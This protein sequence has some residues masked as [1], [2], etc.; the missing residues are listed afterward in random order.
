MSISQP[1]LND[2][3]RSSSACQSAT[4]LDEWSGSCATCS[5]SPRSDR[6][7]WQ[8]PAPCE[9]CVSPLRVLNALKHTA[10][11][12]PGKAAS[13]LR[14]Q[15]SVAAAE[16]RER[17]IVAF[18]ANKWSVTDRNSIRRRIRRCIRHAPCLPS[19]VFK[20]EGGVLYH[21]SL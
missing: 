9:G 1:D 18:D 6:E 17:E 5:L 19:S 8:E 16:Q 3:A 14:L 20:V 2:S 12:P 10:G 4:S 7:G 15:L 13:D 21:P 11:G